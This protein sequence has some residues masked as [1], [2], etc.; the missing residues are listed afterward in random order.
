[1]AYGM[2]YVLQLVRTP[3]GNI[4]VSL[5][6][7]NGPGSITMCFIHVGV[8]KSVLTSGLDGDSSPAKVVVG[9][10]CRDIKGTLFT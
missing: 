1:M 5:C 3:T 6:I 8:V 4:F 7:F 10:Q 2:A 9:Y